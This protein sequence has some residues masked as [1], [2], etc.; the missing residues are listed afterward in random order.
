MPKAFTKKQIDKLFKIKYPEGE[1]FKHNNVWYFAES[2][3]NQCKKLRVNNFYDIAEILNLVDIDTINQM[4]KAAG[5]ESY[6]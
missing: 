4:K 1:L 2:E 5:Y 6:K 3:N